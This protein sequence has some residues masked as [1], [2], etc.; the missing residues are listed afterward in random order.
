MMPGGNKDGYAEL[1]NIFEKIAA[2]TEDGPCVTFVGNGSAG[3]YTKMVH[4]G[5]EYA[6]MQL[7][8][9][10]YDILKRGA[11][12]NNDELHKVFKIWN[13]GEMQSF[14]LEI[15]A[16]IFTHKDEDTGR[17]LVDM[18]LDKAG[19]KGTGKWTSQNSMDLGVPIP[20][21]DAAVTAREISAYKDERVAASG[22]YSNKA[23]TVNLNK[24]KF[25]EQLHD[26]LYF[27]TIVSYAQGFALLHTASS[28]LDMNIPL[29][30]VVKIW[31]GG[32]I[33]RSALLPDFYK[34]YK[35]NPQL[36]NMLLDKRIARMI[37][38][39]EKKLR[40]IIK[41]ATA[42]KIPIPGLSSA[43]AYFDAY[44]SSELP[45]NLIQAQ[46]DFF[47]AHMYQRVDK[48]GMFHNEWQPLPDHK[49]EEV[50]HKP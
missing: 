38:N 12:L 5:I 15:T 2:Q 4:N 32:C 7:I 6:I 19:A 40:T 33:I 28:D 43:L 36:P 13:E 30:D 14:L 48:L 18:I 44:C 20:T 45:T 10:V 17:S 46:R 24:E 47:G 42:L 1:K 11:G 50:E 26:A 27:A 41:Q 25:I 49:K 35:K 39:K 31:R 34:V 16:D 23:R 9:E 21:I 22:L 29:P 37:R 8:S 3:H